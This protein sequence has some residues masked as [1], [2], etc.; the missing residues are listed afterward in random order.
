M[1]ASTG[2]TPNPDTERGP[3]CVD[4]DNL[5]TPEVWDVVRSIDW[6]SGVPVVTYWDY[7][8]NPPADVTAIVTALRHDGVCDCCLDQ[9][10]TLGPIVNVLTYSGGL[11]Y[12][13]G[14]GTAF[15][16]SNSKF[17]ECAPVNWSITVYQGS[18]VPVASAGPSPVLASSAAAL[19]WL[20]AQV[21]SPYMTLTNGTPAGDDWII[22]MPSSPEILVVVT[23][24]AAVPCSTPIEYGFINT[25]Q[26]SIL[27]VGPIYSA[28]NSGIDWTTRA[29]FFWNSL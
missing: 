8:V 12:G 14:G 29:T 22:N 7:D 28:I 27:G 2:F 16:P 4:V 6:S 15:P 11:L 17:V 18:N 25:A 24:T 5:G 9:T 10:S 20:N 1:S 13:I 23:E 3:V 19:A 21:T 26:P